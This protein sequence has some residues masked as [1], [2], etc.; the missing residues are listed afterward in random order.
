MGPEKACKQRNV[1][2]KGIV[3]QTPQGDNMSCAIAVPLQ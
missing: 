3:K 2:G 1:K